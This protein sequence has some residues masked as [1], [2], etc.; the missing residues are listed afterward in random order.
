MA[1]FRSRRSARGLRSR[2][3]VKWI[4]D[5][6]N[7]T[8]ISLTAGTPTELS[9]VEGDDWIPSGPIVKRNVT[10][11]RVVVEA[12]LNVTPAATAF[13]RGPFAFFYALHVIDLEDSDADI[14]TGA[15]G[16]IIQSNRVLHVGVLG[17]IAIEGTA[18][19]ITMDLLPSLPLQI[20]WNGSATMG[21]DDLL[22]LSI[23]P[24]ATQT[25]VITSAAFHGYVRSLIRERY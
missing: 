5:V 23:Q 11:K 7:G 18:G 24:D 15:Q 14:V 20:D 2:K 8:S 21:P 25:A 1:R 16:T 4:T 19:D 17:G 22:L 10:L 3:P 13:E 12:T 9:C 6:F